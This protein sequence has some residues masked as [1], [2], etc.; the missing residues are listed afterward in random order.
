VRIHGHEQVDRAV[1]A[2]LVIDPRDL[3]GRCREGLAHLTDEL[4]G[5]LVEADHRTRRIRRLGVEIEHVLHAGHVFA[6]DLGHAPHLLAPWLELVLGQATAHGLAREAGVI[7]QAYHLAGEQLDGPAG[8][9]LGRAGAGGRD[10]QRF[11]A[12][13]ELALR[14]GA[15]LLGERLVEIAFHEAAPGPVDGRAAHAQALGDGVVRHPGIGR[16]QDLGAL[17]LAGCMPA[18]AS[19]S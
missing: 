5:A 4:N 2:V 13:A 7:G 19:R 11:L 6:I 14:T 17:E 15:G 8:P 16:E 10:Q 1:A 3:P 9:A 12:A 18:A